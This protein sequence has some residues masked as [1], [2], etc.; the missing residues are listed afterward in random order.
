MDAD[1]AAI[2]AHSVNN[3]QVTSGDQQLAY[4]LYTSGSTGRPKGVEVPHRAVVNFLNSMRKRPG[5]TANDVVLA[6]TTLSFDIAVLE[7]FLPLVTGARVVLASRSDA[8]DG[9]RLAK[10]M[11]SERITLLQATPATWRLLL[12]AGWRGRAGLKMLCGGEPLPRD[13]ARE[14]LPRGASL[15]NMY[16][17]TETTVWSSVEPITSAD[18]PM[19]IGRPIDNT[20][21][22][23]LDAGDSLVPV[24]VVGELVIGGAGV[25]RG[26]R[27]RPDLTA[28]RFV[29]D[30]LSGVPG[31]KLYRTGDLARYL[32]D[33]RLECLGRADQQVKLRGFRIELGEIEAALGQHPVVHDSAVQ[34]TPSAATGEANDPRLVAYVVCDAALT[35]RVPAPTAADLQAFLRL[36]LPDYM[37]PAAIVFLAALPRTPNG[38]LDRRLLPEPRSLAGRDIDAPPRTPT[39]REVARLWSDVLHAP[40]VGIHE[41]FFLAGGHSLR[42]AE[43]IARLRETFQMEIPLRSL[44]AAPTVAGVAGIIDSLR[45]GDQPAA[46]DVTV[47]FV[48]ESQLDPVIRPAPGAA[49]CSGRPQA[50]LLTG[51]TGYLGA[52]LLRELL[53]RTDARIYCLVRAADTQSALQKIADNLAMYDIPAD[54]LAPRVISVPGDLAR[55]LLGLPPERFSQMASEV[56]AVYHNGATVNF[57]YPYRLLRGPNVLGTQEVLRLAAQG[58]VKPVHFVSTFSVQASTLRT[59]QDIVS[60]IDELPPCETLH[61][62]YSQTKWVAERLL[63]VAAERGVPVAIYRP[64]RITGHSRT[65]AAN[66]S[67]FLHTMIQGCLQL[68]VAPQLDMEVDMTPVDYVSRAIV[69]LSLRP[70]AIGHAF[71]LVNPQP[72]RMEDLVEWLRATGQTLAVVPLDE[73]RTQ[74]LAAAEQLPPEMLQPL[75]QVFGPLEGADGRDPLARIIH[76][77]FD[78]GLTQR[79]L[80]TAGVHC[81]A[82]DERLLAIYF[83]HLAGAGF[84][85]FAGLVDLAE[86]SKGPH[87]K[88][89]AGVR[90]RG[91]N[92]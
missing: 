19:S 82:V 58:R 89:L 83:Q 80:A 26:Y 85:E 64:G 21:L 77:R 60:E 35:A 14:L 84:F 43:L 3:L 41:D 74:L 92:G 2:A 46:E 8:T 7:L 71:H 23:V 51:A 30:H 40:A 10:L 57:I 22:Y 61:D 13:L 56:D 91:A 68:G 54:D 87:S 20:Q 76:P 31:A 11:D 67:D 6:V 42:A 33:G 86:S 59:A 28:E 27:G 50:V 9:A 70:E 79:L 29:P 47:D 88:P 24:G 38:K 36:T 45:A 69:E 18:G 44:F 53:D 75:A 4:V 90:K 25:A 32:A 66:T 65:G 63:G 15:W 72:P 12:A 16:G 81:P 17:P 48:A 78:S 37:V 62:G 1:R 39:E 52:F 34:L 5:L 73:W 49:H 55:P